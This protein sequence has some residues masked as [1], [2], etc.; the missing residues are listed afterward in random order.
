MDLL[1][2]FL[3]FMGGF[4]IGEAWAALKIRKFIIQLAEQHGID[5]EKEILKKDIESKTEVSKL[6]IEQAENTFLLYEIGT[7]KFIGQGSS[8]DE[9]AKISQQKNIHKA[10]VKHDDKWFVFVEGTAKEFKFTV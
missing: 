2:M 4:L 8:I 7:H 10:A 3:L 9:L 6:Y 1:L 5:L